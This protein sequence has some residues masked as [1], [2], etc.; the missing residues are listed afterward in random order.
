MKT[1]IILD[2]PPHSERSYNGLRMT[3]GLQ[4]TDAQANVTD[5]P[6]ADPVWHGMIG[7]EEGT[8]A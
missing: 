8:N 5:F 7:H 2:D 4:K 1:L 3:H 6:M